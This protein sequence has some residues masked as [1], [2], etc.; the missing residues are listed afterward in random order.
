[1]SKSVMLGTETISNILQGKTNSFTKPAKPYLDDYRL[2]IAPYKPG[3]V[4]YVREAWQFFDSGG[5]DRWYIYKASVAGGKAD[6]N[7]NWKWRSRFTMPRSAARIWLKITQT[8]L[9]KAGDGWNWYIEFERCK[10]PQE[11]KDESV[12]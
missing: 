9:Q 3:D 8:E 7:P 5:T 12:E 4:V 10:E 2:A 1:M 11:E 6:K